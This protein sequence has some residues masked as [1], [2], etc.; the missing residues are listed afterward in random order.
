M[1]E[2][3]LRRVALAEIYRA[4]DR[5]RHRTAHARAAA[6]AA[7]ARQLAVVCEWPRG[8]RC[9][10]AR[11]RRRAAWAPDPLAVASAARQQAGRRRGG[12]APSCGLHRVA[13]PCAG[14][15]GRTCGAEA[16][17]DGRRLLGREHGPLGDEREED[18][19]WVALLQR[20]GEERCALRRDTRARL[21]GRVARAHRRGV[22]RERESWVAW[23]GEKK[24]E[25]TKLG[26]EENGVRVGQGRDSGEP[27]AG[28]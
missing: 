24:G 21:L 15:G 25:R 26:E 14:A 28:H 1:R 23:W 27:V 11:R 22:L 4:G 10:K 12:P 2:V 17:K 9:E 20:A 16:Q 8:E 7:A 6:T 19:P 18:P 3:P 5:R 13:G